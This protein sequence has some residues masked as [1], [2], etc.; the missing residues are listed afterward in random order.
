MMRSAR[1]PRLLLATLVV[2][3]VVG[4]AACG[5]AGKTTATTAAPSGGPPTSAV[6][7][8]GAALAA[9]QLSLVAY[10]TPQAA[11][12]QIIKAFEATPQGKN[13][14]FTESFGASGD[15]SRAVEAGLGADVVAFSLAPDMTRLVKDNIVASSWDSGASKGIVTDSVVALVVRKGNPKNIRTWSDLIRPGVK[16][17]TPNPFTSGGARWN[18]M[19][20]YGAASNAGQNDA[21]GQTYLNALFKNVPVQDNSARAQLQTFVG[22]EGDVMIDYENDAIFAQQKGQAVDYVIPDQTILI[23]NPVAVTSNAKHPA[24]AQAF[25][26]FLYS[27]A[28]QRIFAH[29][30]YRPVKDGIA[31][32]GQFPT[33]PGLFTIG[34]LGGWATV[35]TKFFDP[36]SSVMASIENKLGVSIKK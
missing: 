3:L 26:D 28:A 19:A 11:Y 25:V 16:V 14:T 30:G 17:I 6:A 34:Q 29:N 1:L 32:A 31:A 35:S 10:S 8:A 33:P 20:A 12:D 24:Q 2:G 36:V 23:E 18:V 9:A 13:I 15:Q 21:A 4:L 22:G 7:S 27:D 5:S